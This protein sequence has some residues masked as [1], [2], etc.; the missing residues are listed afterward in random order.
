MP[1]WGPWSAEGNFRLSANAY[2]LDG[3][4]LAIGTSSLQGHGLLDTSFKPPKL[5]VN[6][7]APQ[8]QLDD[9]PLKD[10]SATQI[11]STPEKS[12]EKNEETLRKKASDTSDQLQSVLSAKTL[13]SMNALLS[14]RVDRVIAGHDRLG[15]GKLE[16]TLANGRAVMS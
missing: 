1:P 8:I 6:L 12:T 9:F 16:A 4:N 13:R 2:K 11:K 5:T 15:S 7:S 14:V 10:W 3:L